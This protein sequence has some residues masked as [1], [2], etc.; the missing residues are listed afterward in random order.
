M[1]GVADS[2]EWRCA[3]V[4]E[5][6]VSQQESVV[7]RWLASYGFAMGLKLSAMILVC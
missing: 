4:D 7:M 5:G 6:V 3:C 2:N 1:V